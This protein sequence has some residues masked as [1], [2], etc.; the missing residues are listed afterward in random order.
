MKKK[1]QLQHASRTDLTETAESWTSCEPVL[2]RDGNHTNALRVAIKCAKKCLFTADPRNI[3]CTSAFSSHFV[4]FFCHG[5][6][7]FWPCRDGV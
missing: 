6:R 5:I 4:S 1:K 2:N 7:H 3:L